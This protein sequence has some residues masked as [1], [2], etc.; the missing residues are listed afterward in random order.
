MTGKFR[1]IEASFLFMQSF[2]HCYS[3][4]IFE[5]K[6]LPAFFITGIAVVFLNLNFNVIQL[7]GPAR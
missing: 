6:Y 2:I 3:L 1:S 7:R 4:L 5:K